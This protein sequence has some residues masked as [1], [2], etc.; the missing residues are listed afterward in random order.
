METDNLPELFPLSLEQL[1]RGQG[2]DGELH[3]TD[4]DVVT[5]EVDACCHEQVKDEIKVLAA[6]PPALAFKPR[7][8]TEKHGN[9]KSQRKQRTVYIC[10][11]HC[12]E[13]A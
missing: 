2:K 8:V 13:P 10:V 3:F 12:A 11:C 1:W 9:R 4:D 7:A 5:D 6:A